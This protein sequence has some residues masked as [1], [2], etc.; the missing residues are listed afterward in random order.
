M[1]VIETNWVNKGSIMVVMLKSLCR[2]PHTK[3]SFS[4]LSVNTPSYLLPILASF[5]FTE[6]TYG[7]K[8]EDNWFGSKYWNESL[9]SKMYTILNQVAIVW[10]L[11]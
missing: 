6:V 10:M 5:S 11:D 3:S 9:L 1:T 4:L 7:N 8:L 2:P